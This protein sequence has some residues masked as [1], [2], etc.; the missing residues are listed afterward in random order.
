MLVD[1]DVAGDVAG[2]RQEAGVVLAGRLDA[3]GDVRGVAQEPD[4]GRACRWPA[5]GRP[6]PGPW[7]G[8]RCGPAST[9]RPRR[10]GRPAACWPGRCSPAATRRAAA[11]GPRS[12]RSG[13]SG[14][15]RRSGPPAKRS[16][17]AS[18]SALHRRHGDDSGHE[19]PP[20]TGRSI[21]VEDRADAAVLGEQR[22]AAVAEQVQVERLVGL[23][24]AVALDLDRDGLRRLAGGEGQRAGLGDVVAVAR[25]GGAVRRCGTTSSPP[26]RRRPRA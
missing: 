19:T 25:R 5:G 22:V 23:L 13:C 21:V 12:C 18:S 8:R 20:D 10:P 16:E 24:L 11:A 26:G 3:R 7:A 15:R 17:V 4:L 6:R 9:A 1:A 14:T 2:A